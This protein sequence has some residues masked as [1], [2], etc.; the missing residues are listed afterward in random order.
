MNTNVISYIKDFLTAFDP[1]AF[2]M[3]YENWVHS[4]CDLCLFTFTDSLFS[5][6][7]TQ[8]TPF[9]SLCLRFL[10]IHLSWFSLFLVFTVYGVPLFHPFFSSLLPLASWIFLPGVT[11]L[12]L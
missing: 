8:T 4:M 12:M 3:Q 11:Q 2:I 6:T 5:F 1:R 9:L 7:D 10:S